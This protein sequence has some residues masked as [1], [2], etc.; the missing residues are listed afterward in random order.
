MPFVIKEILSLQDSFKSLNEEIKKLKEERVLLRNKLRELKNNR[1]EENKKIKKE[2]RLLKEEFK[3]VLKETPKEAKKFLQEPA[4]KQE[5]EKSKEEFEL[6]E[7]IFKIKLSLETKS[8]AL[9][10]VKREIKINAYHYFYS[11]FYIVSGKIN[12]EKLFVILPRENA[13]SFSID[14]INL[15]FL[16]KK[17]GEEF[18]KFLENLIN[19]DR[20]LVDLNKI[21]IPFPLH[22]TNVLSF[23]SEYE[24]SNEKIEELF[25]LDTV[26]KRKEK[27]FIPLAPLDP[28]QS[29]SIIGGGIGAFAKEL[30]IEGEPVIL[31][32]SVIKEYK[33]IKRKT[34]EGEEIR[35]IETQAPKIGIYYK[36][37]KEVEMLG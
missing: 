32:G 8:N 20:G 16:I 35:I 36:D 6:E 10:S 34:I 18:K 15:P 22:D 2:N 4:Y 25:P 17:K 21:T 24:I 7:K 11:Y 26:S 1:A 23:V 29:A 5:L 19:E 37:R 30:E 9:N 27:E 3:K 13:N 33:K 31:K 28:M 14:K 12:G